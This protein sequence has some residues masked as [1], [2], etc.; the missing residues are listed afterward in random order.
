MKHWNIKTIIDME[1]FGFYLRFKIMWKFENKNFFFLITAEN[2]LFSQ[3]S[4]VFWLTSASWV[5]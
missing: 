4:E 5:C 2:D 1:T 3:F